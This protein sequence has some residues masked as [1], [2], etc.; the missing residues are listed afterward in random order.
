MWNFECNTEYGLLSIEGDNEKLHSIRMK[1]P[2]ESHISGAA[3]DLRTIPE[4]ASKAIGE[5]L[6]Y[7]QEGEGD[8]S[9]IPL[10]W[11]R[12]TPFER[13]ALQEAQKIPAGETITYGE[14]A[15]RIDRPNAARAVGGALSRN[16]FLLAAP[17]HRIIGADGKMRGFSAEGGI[18]LKAR[19][20]NLEL[21]P[22]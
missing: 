20:L 3:M 21:K 4:W 11:S 8:L 12:L 19:L 6:R 10:D 9:S 17:C 2:Q 16:P 15:R 22:A 14:L 1:D 5:I 7:L 13:S 18:D